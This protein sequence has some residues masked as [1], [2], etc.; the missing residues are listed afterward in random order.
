MVSHGI[1]P[2]HPATALGSRFLPTSCFHGIAIESKIAFPFLPAL[3]VV[4]LPERAGEGRAV[5]I[6]QE[7]TRGVR[8]PPRWRCYSWPNCCSLISNAR[9]LQLSNSFTAGGCHR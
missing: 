6:V 1:V 7:G 3:L 4:P 9:T 5:P 8:A 2:R